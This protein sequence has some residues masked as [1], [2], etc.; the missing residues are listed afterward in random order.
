MDEMKEKNEKNKS[1]VEELTI[2]IDSTQ[3]EMLDVKWDTY[4][5][6]EKKD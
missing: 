3:V 1:K 5:Q 2:N 6:K 4:Y